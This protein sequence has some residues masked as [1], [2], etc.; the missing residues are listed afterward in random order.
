[1]SPTVASNYSPDCA[2]SYSVQAGQTSLA[3]STL[4]VLGSDFNNHPFVKFR[5][6]VSTA[7]WWV[8]AMPSFA[9]HVLSVIGPSTEKEM[10]RINASRVIAFVK[11]TEAIWNWA[12]YQLP[13]K[14]VC[15]MICQFKSKLTIPTSVWA[16]N[17]RPTIVESSLL[18]VTPETINRISPI[19][20][21][22]RLAALGVEKRWMIGILLLHRSVR[23]ICA[24]LRAVS[25]APE[26]SVIVSQGM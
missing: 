12:V 24:T 11:H 3:E 5:F 15:K 14:A 4:S 26:H 21:S 19:E 18:D 16:S 9:H 13:R 23:L 25:A 6:A 1:M 8:T 7:P 10:R 22:R 2:L 20:N 17:P